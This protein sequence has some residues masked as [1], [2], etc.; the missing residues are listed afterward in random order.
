MDSVQIDLQ[1]GLIHYSWRGMSKGSQLRYARSCP[2]KL[3]RMS[4]ELRIAALP[5]RS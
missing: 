3:I 1:Q 4:L 2:N 5:M